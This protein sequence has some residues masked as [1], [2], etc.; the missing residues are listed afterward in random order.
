MREPGSFFLL[1]TLQ[2]HIYSGS[3]KIFDILYYM[4]SEIF[5][6]LSIQISIITYTFRCRHFSLDIAKIHVDDKTY[7]EMYY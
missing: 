3:R 5:K 1:K 2:K 7:I 4:E 6:R